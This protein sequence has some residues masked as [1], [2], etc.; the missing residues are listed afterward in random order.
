MPLP[1]A[2]PLRIALKHGWYHVINR[3]LERRR[4]F[5]AKA[6]FDR[7]IGVLGQLPSR[8]GVLVHAYALMPN[9]YHLLV[10]TP[11][12]NLSQAIQWLNASYSVWFNRKHYRVGPPFRGASK[13]FWWPRMDHLWQTRAC[14]QNLPGC[15]AVLGAGRPGIHVELDDRKKACP[16]EPGSA[17]P[18]EVSAIAAQKMAKKWRRRHSYLI[19]KNVYKF[20]IVRRLP[21]MDSNHDKVIQSHLCYRYTTRQLCGRIE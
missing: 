4:I 10:Q 13:P 12:A 6:D 19:R 2:R 14:R 11:E 20:L 3:G 18:S 16:F 8:F 7:F 17:I 9:H 21:R 1:V 15:D 5:Q